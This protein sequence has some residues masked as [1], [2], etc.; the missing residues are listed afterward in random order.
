M[1][2]LELHS[3]ST[4]EL[5]RGSQARVG[6]LPAVD[7]YASLK[8]WKYSQCSENVK[9]SQIYRVYAEKADH[10]RYSLAQHM[11]I[12]FME[13]SIAMYYTKRSGGRS[14]EERDT[15]T[16][17]STRSELELESPR[18]QAERLDGSW[19]ALTARIYQ[20]GSTAPT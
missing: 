8:L 12:V 9:E 7:Q 17:L 5:Q 20:V 3:E 2:Q 16:Q 19:S 14:S 15:Q 13:C 10:L 18:P 4:A 6:M 1:I 11:S